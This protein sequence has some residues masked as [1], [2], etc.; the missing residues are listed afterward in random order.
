MSSSE[1][2]KKI[3]ALGGTTN[4]STGLDSAE[5]HI[6]VPAESFH[7]AMDLLV[8]MVMSPVFTDEELNKERMVILNE[9]KMRMDDPLTRRMRLLFARSYQDSVYKYP[10]IGYPDTFKQLTREDLEGYHAAV[11]TPER[12]VIGVAGAVDPEEAVKAA[13][14]RISPYVRGIA[15]DPATIPEPRQLSEKEAVFYEDVTLGYLAVAFHTSSLY[16]PELYPGDVMSLMLGEGTD[17]RLYRRLVKEKELLYTVSS[18]NYTPKYPGLYI[19]TGVGSPEKIRQA[20][21]EIFN[22]IDEFVS[23]GADDDEIERAKNFVIADHV[24]SNEGVENI[25][26]SMTSSY[27]LTGSPAFFDDYVS[28]I[29][30]VMPGEAQKFASK[31]LTEENSTTVILYPQYYEEDSG[32]EARTSLSQ[33]DAPARMITLDNGL[34]V[35]LKEKRRLPIVSVTLAFP[36]GLRVENEQNNGICNLTSGMLLKGTKKRTEEEIVPPVE[37]NGGS[38]SAFSGM[39]SMGVSASIFGEDLEDVID[40]ISDVSQNATFPEEE[41]E[42]YRKKVL[43]SIREEEKDIFANG[44]IA[45]RKL[46]YRD[47]PYGMRTSGTVKTVEGLTRQDLRS[48]YE[49]RVAPAGAVLSVVGDIDS[50]A[51]EELVKKKFAK[52]RGEAP[53]VEDVPVAPIVSVDKKELSMDKMQSLVLLGFQG[54]KAKSRDKYPLAVLASLL[55]GSD[56]LMFTALREEEGLTYTSGAFSLPEADKG[57]FAIYSATAEE[58]VAKTRQIII[59]LLKKVEAGDISDEQITSSKMRLI[60]QYS[61]SF[62]ANSYLSLVMAVDEIV[63]LGYEDYKTFPDKIRAVSKEAVIDAAGKY[64]DPRKHA[65]VIISPGSE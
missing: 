6:T 30:K 56:G 50:S 32:R 14:S 16:S 18:V 10:I 63:G 40:I 47:H 11:Y 3:K 27:L 60:T 37:Q 35:V 44:M 52:W 51:L 2:R 49:K 13:E 48:F 62:Q 36:G 58:N 54:V 53:P 28:G 55:S 20:R 61:Q 39:N 57:Y 5:Y 31:Y 1:I 23:S 26:A 29:K 17:S 64:L 33:K 65:L 4:A 59:E 8:D 24:Y 9:L 7:E 25:T 19:I 43:A 34:K 21:K 46:I 45:L 42:K 41:L 12:V 15:W 38:I 22:V